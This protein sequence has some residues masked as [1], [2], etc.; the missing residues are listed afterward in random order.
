MIKIR[1][2]SGLHTVRAELVEALLLTTQPFDKLR[3]NGGE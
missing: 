1:N 3:A 2:D